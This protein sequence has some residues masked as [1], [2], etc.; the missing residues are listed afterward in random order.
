MHEY[1]K[2]NDRSGHITN[3]YW[4]AIGIDGPVTPLVTINGRFNS[5]Q[6]MRILRTHLIP[7]MQ[8]FANAGAPR[9]FMQDNSPVHTAENVMN[10][11]S[12]QN[13]VVMD[14]PAKSPDLNPIENVWSMMEIGWPAIHPRNQINLHTVVQDRW[15]D[16]STNQGMYFYSLSILGKITIDFFDA[17]LIRSICFNF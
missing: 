5:Q 10:F 4:G 9:I 15:R 2:V 11:F 6:Y 13:F 16:L 17:L 3:N 12:R 1:M 8:R 14:W 7:Q